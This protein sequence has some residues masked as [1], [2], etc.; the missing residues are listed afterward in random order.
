M[1]PNGWSGQNLFG[2]G[3]PSLSLPILFGTSR[4]SL[5]NT[6]YLSVRPQVSS[7]RRQAQSC[8]DSIACYCPKLTFIMNVGKRPSAVPSSSTTPVPVTSVDRASV[9]FSIT[10]KLIK[11]LL[12]RGACLDE[13]GYLALLKVPPFGKGV[14][15]KTDVEG[16]SFLFVQV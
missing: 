13:I 14:S 10:T 16:A 15:S 4:I 2:R 3:R 8:V 5:C 6:S 1:R 12:T 9:S 7:C 11:F